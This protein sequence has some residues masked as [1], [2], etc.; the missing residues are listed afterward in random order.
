[1]T[2]PPCGPF[3]PIQKS[4]A[5]APQGTTRARTAPTMIASP[6]RC[7]D[8]SA[9]LRFMPRCEFP[10]LAP[11][12][13]NARVWL[14]AARDASAREAQMNSATSARVFFSSVGTTAPSA[15]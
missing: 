9:S 3:V 6:A 7:G 4:S 12:L 1:M 13:N 11:V 14:P 10:P 8:V 15:G 5:V 2:S